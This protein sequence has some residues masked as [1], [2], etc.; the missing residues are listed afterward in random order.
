MTINIVI[1]TMQSFS[2]DSIKN[3]QNPTSGKSLW[4]EISRVLFTNYELIFVRVS[5]PVAINI[6]T[7][8]RE[9]PIGCRR[10][11]QYRTLT[12]A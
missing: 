10:Q 6:T 8:G 5:R 2:T 12:G 1:F 11:N 7:I 3:W 4:F 9:M